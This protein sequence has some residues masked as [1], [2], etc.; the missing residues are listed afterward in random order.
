MIFC[1]ILLFIHSFCFLYQPRICKKNRADTG[2]IDWRIQKTAFK[3][4]NARFSPKTKYA[5][6][7][8]R[9]SPKKS[10]PPRQSIGNN[11]SIM[12]QNRMMMSLQV[13]NRIIRKIKKKR[14]GRKIKLI[15]YILYWKSDGMELLI[16]H[17]SGV[18]GF[19][20]SKI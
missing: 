19:W 3:P 20:G 4:Q 8:R 1:L 13:R 9:R 14:G 5:K 11:M 10:K 15:Y 17:I 2:R 7:R 18:L 6:M 16:F 12:L